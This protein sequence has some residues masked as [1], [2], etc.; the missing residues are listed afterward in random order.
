MRELPCLQG[1]G[2]HFRNDAK[3]RS[4]GLVFNFLQGVCAH[5]SGD[6]RTVTMYCRLYLR[7]A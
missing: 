4:I 6:H 7:V 1:T 5:R 2:Y 3:R